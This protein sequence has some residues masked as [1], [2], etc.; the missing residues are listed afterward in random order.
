MG[1]NYDMYFGSTLIQQVQNGSL[2][3]DAAKLLTAGQLE[4]IQNFNVVFLGIDLTQKPELAF[5]ALLIF[6]ILSVLTMA[7]T[8]VITMKMSG[9]E[10]QGSMKWM[11][12]IMSLMFVWFGF[13]VPVAFSLYYTVSNLL[14]FAQSVILKKIYDP[15]K[16]KQQ[17]QEEIEAKKKAKKAKKQI[18]TVDPTGQEVLKE[19]TESEMARLRLEMARKL[20]EEKYKDERTTPLAEEAKEE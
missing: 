18:K 4:A 6:P 13:T 9:Q 11:P 16:M 20:D 3:A 19:V 14:M 17:V 8:N 7:L 1:L 12:W 15:E 2:A 5:N 10:M